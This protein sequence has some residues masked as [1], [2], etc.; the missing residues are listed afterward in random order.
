MLLKNDGSVTEHFTDLDKLNMAKLVYGDFGF[1]IGL[2][3]NTTTAS[4]KSDT[5]FKSDQK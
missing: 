5:R 3:F 1:W 4:Y 2:I